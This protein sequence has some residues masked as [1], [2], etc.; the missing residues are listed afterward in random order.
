MAPKRLSLPSLWD[1]QSGTCDPAEYHTLGQVLKEKTTDACAV[2]HGVSAVND[3]E[4]IVG[5]IVTLDIT[6]NLQP[7]WDAHVARVKKLRI[8]NNLISSPTTESRHRGDERSSYH[9]RDWSIHGSIVKLRVVHHV[10][11]LGSQPKVPIRAEVWCM[12]IAARVEKQHFVCILAFVQLRIAPQN[13]KTPA[14]RLK[15]NFKFKNTNGV[16]FNPT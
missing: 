5:V 14:V 11:L 15:Y 12:P 8:L 7:L 13:P 3:N 2:R 16:T 1:W 4:C 10:G 9:Q 6:S